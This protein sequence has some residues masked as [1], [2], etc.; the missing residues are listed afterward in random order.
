MDS[1]DVAEKKLSGRCLEC[2]ERLPQHTNRCPVN[3]ASQ[4]TRH[5]SHI[6][7]GIEQ[8][9]KQAQDLIES[10]KLD[11][12]EVQDLLDKIKQDRKDV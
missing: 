4:I 12:A 6:M 2:G 7:T 10:N 11:I 1:I 8:K 9:M 3:P 5:I